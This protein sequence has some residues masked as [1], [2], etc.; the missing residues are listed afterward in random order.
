VK[1]KL[2]KIEKL[3]YAK[4]YLDNENVI[5]SMENSIASGDIKLEDIIRVNNQHAITLIAQRFKIKKSGGFI[6]NRSVVIEDLDIHGDVESQVS[7]ARKMLNDFF[8]NATNIELSKNKNNN[9]DIYIKSD[10]DC[11]EQ[12][13]LNLKSVLFS[14]ITRV[15]YFDIEEKNQMVCGINNRIEAIAF[16]NECMEHINHPPEGCLSIR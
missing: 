5:D 9:Y 10:A 11:I 8:P 1:D 7:L 16:I 4:L 13:L 2:L 3:K 15:N 14:E 6:M 12:V